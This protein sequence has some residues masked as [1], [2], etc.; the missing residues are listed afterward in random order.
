MQTIFFIKKWAA[1]CPPKGFLRSLGQ[2]QDLWNCLQC[3][4]STYI[5]IQCHYVLQ[6]ESKYF[7][8]DYNIVQIVLQYLGGQTAIGTWNVYTFVKK[9]KFIYYNIVTTAWDPEI[10]CYRTHARSNVFN[11]SFIQ[12]PCTFSTWC[13]AIAALQGFQGPERLERLSR[14]F[15]C[16]GTA[17]CFNLHSS[18]I[19]TLSKQQLS[20]LILKKKSA[21][22]CRCVL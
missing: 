9:Q 11:G 22:L 3:I 7:Q 13:Y 2:F 19:C 17:G 20:Y 6:N 8:N 16:I 10:L 4:S 15:S 1:F 14:S 18:N 12:Y 21:V 5:I